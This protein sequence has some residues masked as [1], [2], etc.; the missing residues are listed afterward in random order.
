MS[1]LGRVP[2]AFSGKPGE[3]EGWLSQMEDYLCVVEIGM[4]LTDSQKIALLRNCVGL[5]TCEIID[6]FPTKPTTY[7]ELKSMLLE[8]FIPQKNITYER[9][10]FSQSH[11]Q[12]GEKFCAYL[13]NLQRLAASCD[14]ASSSPDTIENQRIRDQFIVGIADDD[15]RKRLLSEQ[16]LTLGRLKKIAITM[17]AS[18]ETVSKLHRSEVQDMSITPQ[19]AQTSRIGRDPSY[20]QRKC[21][22]CSKPGHIAAECRSSE[23]TKAPFTCLYCHNYFHEI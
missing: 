13:N 22:K 20:S 16:K 3:I 18:S 2:N 17:E 23:R 15:V 21:F 14:F 19:L 1:Q 12:S 4:S 11:Q 5:Q 10:V 6:A 8:H 9:Y 7:K